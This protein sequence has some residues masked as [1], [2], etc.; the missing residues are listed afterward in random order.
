MT[1][2]N[3]LLDELLKGCKRPED[4]LG[5]AGLMKAEVI[6]RRGPW[7][8]F[9]AEERAT[10]ERVDWFKNRRLLETV[11]NVPPAEAEARFHAAPETEPMA[12]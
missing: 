2:S 5:D 1:I 7:R 11:G 4:L 6:H 8:S 9:E 12:A 3:E 10:L